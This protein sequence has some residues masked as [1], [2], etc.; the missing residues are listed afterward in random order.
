[1]L[2]LTKIIFFSLLTFSVLG[3]F[4]SDK[5]VF[6]QSAISCWLTAIGNPGDPAPVLPP[7]CTPQ[8]NQGTEGGSKADATCPGNGPVTCG[9][10]YA[11]APCHC[12]Q[13]YQNNVEGC[14]GSCSWCQP[15]GQASSA[16]AIDI[17]NP[18]DA[19]V[20]IPKIHIPGASDTHS[21]TCMGYDADISGTYEPTQI[22]QTVSCADDVTDEAVWLHFHHS[23]GDTPTIPDKIYKTGDAVGKS[24]AF[25]LHPKIGTHVHFQIGVD[26]PCEEHVPGSTNGCKPADDYVQC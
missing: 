26:G 19:S 1:M 6:A 17:S 18:E 21:L 3:A 24:G 9:S 10:L 12:S 8:N 14:N 4:F 20:Y 22:I 7:E 13:D 25:V 2:K 16:F 15:P 11:S 23:S 5:V